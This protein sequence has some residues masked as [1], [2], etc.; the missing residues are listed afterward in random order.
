MIHILGGVDFLII[1]LLE[2]VQ[3]Y[4]ICFTVT[5]IKEYNNAQSAS[6]TND[7]MFPRDI[8]SGLAGTGTLTPGKS[9]CKRDPCRS[10]NIG[11]DLGLGS[12]LLVHRY[13]PT[14]RR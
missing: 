14:G 6:L 1:L 11:E 13:V 5:H 2:H 4:R 12:L 8:C 9:W 3:A 10:G 7:V